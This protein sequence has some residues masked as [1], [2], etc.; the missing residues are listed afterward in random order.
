M[1]LGSN[2]SKVRR[3]TTPVIPTTCVFEIPT[4]YQETLSKTRFLLMDFFLKRAK[5][6]VI[7]YATAQQL[8]LLFSSET[9]FIDGT[10]SV[11]PNTFEQVF[12]IHV[13]H[14]GQGKLY[15]L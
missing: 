3:K 10:F 1:F 12:L 7:V 5:E 6:R 13:Q 15:I 4:F 9:I 2:M 14:L 11:A 8:Q